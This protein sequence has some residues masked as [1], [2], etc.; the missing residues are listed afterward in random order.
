MKIKDSNEAN[1]VKKMSVILSVHT[2]EVTIKDSDDANNANH[3]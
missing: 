2:G 3:V 1:D